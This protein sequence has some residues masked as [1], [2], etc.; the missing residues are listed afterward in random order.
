[1]NRQ[2]CR[3]L[4]AATATALVHMAHRV[5]ATADLKAVRTGIGTALRTLLS[6]VLREPVPDRMGELLRQLD[7]PATRL[8]C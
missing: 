4:G 2:K 7:Q 1:M 6:D 3:L 5:E 8:Q